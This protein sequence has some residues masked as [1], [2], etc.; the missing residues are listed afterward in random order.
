MTLHPPLEPFTTRFLEVGARILPHYV[1]GFSETRLLD[2][3]AVEG[4]F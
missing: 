2:R 3:F 1:G 4:R